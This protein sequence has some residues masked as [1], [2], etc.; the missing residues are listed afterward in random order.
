MRNWRRR[1]RVVDRLGIRDSK[2]RNFRKPS[3]VTYHSEYEM[4]RRKGAC[5][6]HSYLH[7]VVVA[8]GQIQMSMVRA[9][10]SGQEIDAGIYREASRLI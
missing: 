3:K 8:A 4:G 5:T 2:H 1:V 6:N 9:C 7:I 10:G